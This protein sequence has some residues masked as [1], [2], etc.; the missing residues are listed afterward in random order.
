MQGALQYGTRLFIWDAFHH[1]PVTSLPTWYPP[2]AVACRMRFEDT[3]PGSHKLRINVVDPDGRILAQMGVTFSFLPGSPTTG[4]LSFTF[5]P[6]G[7]EIRCTGDYA[8]D[9]IL[10][11]LPPVRTPFQVQKV[12]AAPPPA[13]PPGG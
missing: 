3:A 8:I 2:Y 13:P 12:D 6:V 11:E 7:M 1:I 10:D 5:Y 9:L 4:P